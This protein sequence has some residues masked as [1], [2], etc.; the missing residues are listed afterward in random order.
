MNVSERHKRRLKPHRLLNGAPYVCYTIP[1]E[2]CRIRNY[3]GAPCD[4][5]EKSRV[6]LK[7]IAA[8]SKWLH[9]LKLAKQCIREGANIY[10]SF[11]AYYRCICEPKRFTV[12]DV[13]CSVRSLDLVKFLL[14]RGFDIHTVNLQRME[15]VL[16]EEKVSE[17]HLNSNSEEDENDPNVNWSLCDSDFEEFQEH[18]PVTDDQNSSYSDLR[19]DENSQSVNVSATDSS[20]E[21][22]ERDELDAD[23]QNSSYSELGEDEN[24]QSVNVSATDSS[25]EEEERD[26]L[27]ADNGEY[28]TDSDSSDI[29]EENEK[30]KL[31]L[32]RRYLIT[33]GA[34]ALRQRS[35]VER[36]DIIA[37]D[38]VRVLLTQIG[39][40]T[41]TNIDMLKS[42]GDHTGE[43]V[44][45]KACLELLVDGLSI[46]ETGIFKALQ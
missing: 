27:E 10:S 12:M 40:N 9:Q 35:R 18:Q 5:C 42:I 45:T 38:K 17:Y 19:E 44:L 34:V 25:S 39:G 36:L 20:S 22:E 2:C 4:K 6:L 30:V 26:E 33:A 46:E 24:S 43:P 8:S 14:Q 15:F 32:I 41:F 1:C 7:A 29:M 11:H 37:S 23:N 21:E 28:V 16:T 31:Q 13:A 3:A